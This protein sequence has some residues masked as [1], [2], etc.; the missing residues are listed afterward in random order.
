M[1][2]S[3]LKNNL[4]KKNLSLTLSLSNC[5]LLFL[6]WK[7]GELDHSKILN[8]AI[9]FISFWSLI[10]KFYKYWLLL[11]ISNRVNK[12]KYI[13]KIMFIST[14]TNSTCLIENCLTTKAYVE[15]LPRIYKVAVVWSV[16][17]LWLT[18]NLWNCI[19]FNRIMIHMT[20]YLCWNNDWHFM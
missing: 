12:N 10:I 13:S 11:S 17:F 18:F 19:K 7:K 16:F 1:V 6:I 2:L 8:I 3:L 4:E 5:L 20:P 9:L 14:F 15:L